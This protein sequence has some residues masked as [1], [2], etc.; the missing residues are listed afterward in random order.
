MCG[1]RACHGLAGDHGLVGKLWLVGPDRT[2]PREVLVEERDRL[3]VALALR[4]RQRRVARQVGGAAG[5]RAVR[6]ERLDRLALPIGCRPAQRLRVVPVA[7]LDVRVVAR[8]DE[9]VD[10][11]DVTN[12]GRPLERPSQL[13]AL[14]AVALDAAGGDVADLVAARRLS[15]AFVEVEARRHLRRLGSLAAR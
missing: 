15:K 7:H 2:R 11:L 1:D 12:H 9:C 10:G 6:A 8:G 5:V 13:I 4:V 14:E 3:R